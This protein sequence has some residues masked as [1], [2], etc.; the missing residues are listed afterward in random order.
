MIAVIFNKG[1]IN[2]DADVVYVIITVIFIYL[3]K[4]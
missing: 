3:W 4:L 1:Y 2:N